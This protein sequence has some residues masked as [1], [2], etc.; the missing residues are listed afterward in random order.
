MFLIP[1]CLTDGIVTCEVIC[2]YFQKRTH[3]DVVIFCS[4]FN[5]LLCGGML[6]RS[7]IFFYVQIGCYC[8]LW[9]KT[10]CLIC[11]QGNVGLLDSDCLSDLCLCIWGLFSG[12]KHTI[13]HVN[14]SRKITL[15]GIFLNQ[16]FDFIKITSHI[17]R[18]WYVVI[19]NSG[20]YFWECRKCLNYSSAAREESHQKSKLLGSFLQNQRK[21]LSRKRVMVVL[22]HCIFIFSMYFFL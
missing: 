11:R 13:H 8:W 2:W 9:S 15:Q 21:R 22:F 20:K 19:N 3:E 16:L 6:W 1:Y 5:F 12:W 18:K 4:S 10:N 14:V 17:T 7:T